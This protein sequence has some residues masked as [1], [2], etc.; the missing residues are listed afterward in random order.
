MLGPVK[1][2]SLARIWE[3]EI[4]PVWSE[5][6]GRYLLRRLE[7]PP[8][9][10]VLDA[11]CGTGYPTLALLD[12]MDEASRVVG[13]DSSSPMLDIARRRAGGLA[14][15]RVFLKVEDVERLNFADEVFDLAVSNLML[16]ELEDPR[17]AL[18]EMHRVTRPGGTLG[19]TLALRGT[20][21]EFLDLYREALEL[22]EM[23]DSLARLD[24]YL[25]SFPDPA[26][27]QRMIESAGYSDVR[28]DV[29]RFSLLF[30]SSRE[31]FFAPVIEHGFLQRWKDLTPGGRVMQKVFLTV[32]RSIDTYLGH[33]PLSLTVSAGC[34]VAR[35]GTSMPSLQRHAD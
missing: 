6:F 28:V 2:E 4:V 32:K 9:S 31:F 15:K 14:G 12:Q 33:G 23:D 7:I 29:H 20:F 8:K 5:P 30:K 1:A 13:I 34:V 26:G 3:Q 17:R 21:V 35:K 25:E 10:M 24:D 18:F 11:G 22:A 16:G 27:L 19:A